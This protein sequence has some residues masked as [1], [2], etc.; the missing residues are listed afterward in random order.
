MWRYEGNVK[1]A[2]LL[3]G[4]ICIV[5]HF[6]PVLM[7]I[8]SGMFW[9]SFSELGRNSFM[10]KRRGRECYSGREHCQVLVP[11]WT[12][13]AK[14]T[15]PEHGTIVPESLLLLGPHNIL[16]LICILSE[17]PQRRLLQCW[18][19]EQMNESTHPSTHHL[20]TNTMYPAVCTEHKDAKCIPVAE[21]CTANGRR[22]SRKGFVLLHVAS[23]SSWIT[24][25]GLWGAQPCVRHSY[26]E[27]PGTDSQD[28]HPSWDCGEGGKGMGLVKCSPNWGT[29]LWGTD[30]GRSIS[31]CSLGWY[32]KCQKFVGGQ[33]ES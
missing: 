7:Y 15:G 11:T 33:A 29:T 20:C 14:R 22:R 9:V 10:Q 28:E 17:V 1:K 5:F 13:K 24:D 4:A 6:F 27:K 31:G 30:S 19:N 8:I 12:K 21:E 23:V 16:V 18:M 32:D 2:N 25:V 3:L 26:L